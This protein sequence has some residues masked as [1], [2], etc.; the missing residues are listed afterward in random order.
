[1]NKRTEGIP[2]VES[3]NIGIYGLKIKECVVIFRAFHNINRNAP[4]ISFYRIK[5]IYIV[6]PLTANLFMSRC[7]IDS[8][9]SASTVTKV[10]K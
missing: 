3:Y 10:A 9:T 8:Q 7:A 2:Q 5:T 1:M 4:V 6:T